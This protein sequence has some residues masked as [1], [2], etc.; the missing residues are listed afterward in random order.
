MGDTTVSKGIIIYADGS[1]DSFELQRIKMTELD[2]NE[3]ITIG[4]KAANFIVNRVI[5]QQAADLLTMGLDIKGTIDGHNVEYV[6]DVTVPM[7]TIDK[8]HSS[9]ARSISPNA[10]SISAPITPASTLP[11][12]CGGNYWCDLVLA[13]I[14][15]AGIDTACAYDGVLIIAGVCALVCLPSI[16]TGPGYVLWIGA[17]AVAAIAAG[18]PEILAEACSALEELGVT[19]AG[20]KSAA[21]GVCAQIVCP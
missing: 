6:H 10:N 18:V 2:Y 4:N 20:C 19:N 3:S 17:C 7:E 12:K 5:K 15:A 14:C 13:V 21:A 9:I 1:T 16:E 8:A 11:T